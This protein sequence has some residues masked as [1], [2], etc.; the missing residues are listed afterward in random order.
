MVA[1]IVPDASVLLKW[2]LRAAAEEH[3]ERALILQ[4]SWLSGTHDLVV[5]T[6]WVYEVGNV[7]A[8]KQPGQ[9]EALL[10]SMMELRLPEV[11][12][13]DYLK[14]ILQ[15]IRR[16][17]VTFYDAAYHALALARGGLMLT[18]DRRY[19]DRAGAAGRVQLLDDWEP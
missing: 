12:P 5:P 8:V 2:T 6:L 4:R 19:V 15:L 11:P 17:R 18:A 10:E 7:L 16:F 3:R 14:D 1:L 13:V 9:V